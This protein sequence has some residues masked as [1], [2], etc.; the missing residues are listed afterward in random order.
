[1]ET[2]QEGFTIT[3]KFQAIW[4]P[5]YCEQ[6]EV[7][8]AYLQGQ[9]SP[10]G[11][12]HGP[13]KSPDFFFFFPSWVLPGQA[14]HRGSG[15]ERLLSCCGTSWDLTS[16]HSAA[17]FVKAQQK[18]SLPLSAFSAGLRFWARGFDW[19]RGEE[20]LSARTLQLVQLVLAILRRKCFF[21]YCNFSRSAACLRVR[22]FPAS[23][24]FL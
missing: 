14:C 4:L 13:H 2:E 23:S 20:L 18:T 22:V 10:T 8:A 19:F 21:W 24:D 3:C 16:C 11:R 7:S 9:S 12:T 6:R 15:S 17:P 1:M 5:V